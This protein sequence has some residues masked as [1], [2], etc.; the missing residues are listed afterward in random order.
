[1]L[2]EQQLTS[3]CHFLV[4][5]FTISLSTK[6][7]EK[8]ERD[9]VNQQCERYWLKHYH[10]LYWV[11]LTKLEAICDYVWISICSCLMLI[12]FLIQIVMLSPKALWMSTIFL[13]IDLDNQ[14]EEKMI[15]RLLSRFSHDKI[16]WIMINL[17]WNQLTMMSSSSIETIENV[18]SN[19]ISVRSASVIFL[20]SQTNDW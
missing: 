12:F 8:R 13:R 18:F 1:M 9:Q 19:L 14:S 6:K 10:F 2:H 3:S 11:S 20:S 5:C 4:E 15:R 17:H 16:I 7:E